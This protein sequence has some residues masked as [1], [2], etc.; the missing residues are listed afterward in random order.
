MMKI[1]KWAFFQTENEALFLIVSLT[2]VLISFTLMAC[3]IVTLVCYPILATLWLIVPLYFGWKKVIL[4]YKEK[5]N[6]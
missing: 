1:A 6:E 4:A 3:F 5:H 2:I